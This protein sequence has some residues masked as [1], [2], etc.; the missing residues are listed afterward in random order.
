MTPA[1]SI[2]KPGLAVRLIGPA[3]NP[4]AV[5]AKIRLLAP[6][7]S[8]PVKE[9]Q[10]GS[11]YWSHNSAVQVFGQPDHFSEISIQWPGGKETRTPLPPKARSV[12]IAMDGKTTFDN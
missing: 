11:G 10:A 8:S 7:Q 5:G 1:A 4:S 9:I 2:P 3:E 12:V 6:A